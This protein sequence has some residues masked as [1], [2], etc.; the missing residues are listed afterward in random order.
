MLLMNRVNKEKVA[1]CNPITYVTS[2][3]PPFLIV[4][5][6]QDPLVPYGQS[7][8]LVEALQKAGVEVTFYTSCRR[9]AWALHGPIPAGVNKGVFSEIYYMTLAVILIQFIFIPEQ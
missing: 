8:L 5:G 9:R 2:E 7:V 1:R 4:H 3:A 6:N